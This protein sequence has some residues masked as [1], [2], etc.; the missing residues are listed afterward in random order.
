[1]KLAKRNSIYGSLRQVNRFSKT[2]TE[3]M[4]G[5]YDPVTEHLTAVV[6]LTVSTTHFA[7]PARS[8]FGQIDYAVAKDWG[9]SVGLC[10]TEYNTAVVN[11]LTITA[12]HYW[13]DYRAVYT[14]YQNFL[15]GQGAVSSNQVLF[16]KYYGDRNWFGLSGSAGKSFETIDT[17][18]VV[19]NIR[20]LVFSGRH[21]LQP[22]LALTYTI[23]NYHQ[24]NFY[25]RNGIQLGLR[26]QF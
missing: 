7:L 17:T 2:D 9:A 5:L 19:S 20:T 4:G 15:P 8:F 6:E 14:R 1:M 12:D 10:H 22:R 11:L 24:D 26:R 16:A 21:W 23:G 18:Q 13:G 25:I 3:M